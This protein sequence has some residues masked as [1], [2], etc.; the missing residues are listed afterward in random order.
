MRRRVMR[1]KEYNLLGDTIYF[2][3]TEWTNCY[4]VRYYTNHIS[5]RLTT[6][7]LIQ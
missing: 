3:N 1:E 4:N 7:L 6:G 2:L 5:T